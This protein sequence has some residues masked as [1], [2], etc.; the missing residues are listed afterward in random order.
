MRGLRLSRMP[1]FS[2]RQRERKLRLS[3]PNPPGT[4]A[5]LPGVNGRL[6]R[7]RGL[8]RDRR[9]PGSAKV[10]A[11]ARKGS[12]KAQAGLA[13]PATEGNPGRRSGFGRFARRV[14]KKVRGLTLPIRKPGWERAALRRRSRP[15]KGI[16]RA[17]TR[18]RTT[19]PAGRR[20]GRRAMELG[21]WG[22]VA[23]PAPITVSAPSG[24]WSPFGDAPPPAHSPIRRTVSSRLKRLR[25]VP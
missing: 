24:T 14:R 25:N 13:P 15:T 9:R 1:S 22:P 16:E 17:H 4:A 5:G 7:N 12:W 2:K 23:T 18:S 8:P 6:P 11:G 10:S 20:A 3:I 19:R 21:Q